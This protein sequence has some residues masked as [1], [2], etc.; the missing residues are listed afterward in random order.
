MNYK[1]MLNE[2]ETFIGVRIQLQGQYQQQFDDKDR[3][4]SQLSDVKAA[5]KTK[6]AELEK[7]WGYKLPK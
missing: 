1:L 6:V 5:L 7:N 3:E 2:L 4:I